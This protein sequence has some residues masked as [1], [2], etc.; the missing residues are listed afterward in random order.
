MDY[1]QEFNNIYVLAKNYMNNPNELLPL[2]NNLRRIEITLNLNN[3]YYDIII[4]RTSFKNII[5]S[6][7]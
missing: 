2:I 1:K 4:I 3:N 5:K 7:K 6:T